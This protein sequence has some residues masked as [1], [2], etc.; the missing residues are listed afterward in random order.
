MKH[1][2]EK[3]DSGFTVID[4]AASTG[5]HVRWLREWCAQQAAM[6]VLV[7]LDGEGDDDADLCYILPAAF[8]EVLADPTSS[9]YDIAMIQ[10]VPSLLARARDSIPEAFRTGLGMPYDDENIA[11]AIDR[12][13]TVSIRHFVIPKLLPSIADG[14]VLAKLESG[15]RVADLG[16]GGGNLLIEMAHRFPFSEFHG[17]EV[18]DVA[19]EH[20]KKAIAAAALRNA[21]VHDA[22][23]AGGSIDSTP[24]RFDLILTYDVLHDAPQ[25]QELMIAARRAL[26][27]HGVWLIADIK[28]ADGVRANMRD[29]AAKTYWAFSTC[30][31]M[32]S[33]LSEP[34]GKGLGTLGFSPR[35]AQRMLRDAGF[36][37]VAVVADE[38]NQRWWEVA[39]T[40]PKAL[41]CEGCEA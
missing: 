1:L 10:A 36:G 17:Y 41:V 25:P 30:L 18:S 37:H 24:A 12:Q 20:A 19:I 27:P 14:H 21:H 28:C 16:C 11:S 3:K 29:G 23:K 39:H 2:C 9:N 13:H 4:L 35:V 5:L 15:A 38:G 26:A 6:G 8:A 33:A 34:N 31:C 7:L 22:R 40:G 32:A